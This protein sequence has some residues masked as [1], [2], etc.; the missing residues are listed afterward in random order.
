MEAPA[1]IKACGD[2]KHPSSQTLVK[3][4]KVKSASDVETIFDFPSVWDLIVW[5]KPNP[6]GAFALKNP[7]VKP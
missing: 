7:F 2:L 4:R 1:F 5:V 6:K 3:L